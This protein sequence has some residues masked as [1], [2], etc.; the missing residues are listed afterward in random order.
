LFRVTNT[1]ASAAY[2]ITGTSSSADGAGIAGGN[3]SSGVGF[4]GQSATGIGA[5]GLHVGT[6]ASLAAGVR[7]QTNAAGI[8]WGVEGLAGADPGWYW[9]TNIGVRGHSAAG[10]GVSGETNSGI[11]AVGATY[12]GFGVYGVNFDPSGYALWSNGRAQVVGD[13]SVSG[14]FSATGTKAFKIDNPLQ[15][16]RQ[17]LLHAAVESDQALNSYSGNVTTDADGFATVKLPAYVAAINKDFRYQLTIVGRSGWGAEAIVWEKL[18]ND[19]FTIRTSK[20]G[21]E[22][23]W[24][25]SGVRNDPYMRAHPFQPVQ[26]KLGK[27]RGTYLNPRLYGKP[28]SRSLSAISGPKL[29]KLVRQQRK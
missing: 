12:T 9:G 18:K 17:Y 11:G 22:V 7:G 10:F 13:L 15:P 2:A 20:P 16:A 26:Q 29:P 8:G 21:V 1:G 24:Q 25:L 14:N 3:T 28:T 23:S 6:A 5:A 27:E 19:S 4:R